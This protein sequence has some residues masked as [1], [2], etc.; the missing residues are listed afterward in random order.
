MKIVTRLA[1]GACVAL[2]AMTPVSA[3]HSWGS[4]HWA[5]TGNPLVLQINEALSTT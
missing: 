3:E 1:L 2:G 4:Y 5:R